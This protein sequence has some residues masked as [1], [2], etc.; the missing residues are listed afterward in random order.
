MI[1]FLAGLG[2]ALLLSGCV[3]ET[4][5][6]GPRKNS[7]DISKQIES[8]I[9]LG[10]GYIRNQEYQR[11]KDNLSRAIKLDPGSAHAHT[12]L[13]Y[14]F[15]L[16]GENEAAEQYF[17]KAI[18]LDPN[19]SL[20]RNNFGAFL[21]GLQRYEEAAA[22]LRKASEDR[23]YAKR[24]Q[25]FENLGMCYK[26]L[27]RKKEAEE[28]FTRSIQL[29]PAQNRALLEMTD[30]R[31]KQRNYV[32]SQSFYTRYNKVAG[33][34][35]KSLWLGIQLARIFNKEDEVASY[36]LL[37]KNVFPASPEYKAFLDSPK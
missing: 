30:I 16:E 26:E 37:L 31:F 3:T 11:A 14:V 24:S 19:Y 36:A 35:A 5:G 6:T 12:M 25:V 20:A 9:A 18:K 17:R 2:L 29:N 33:H 10:V 1:R 15:Q 7:G 34:N 28:A 32:E 13:G 4:I 23:I 27:N 8:Y 22:Q 21:F